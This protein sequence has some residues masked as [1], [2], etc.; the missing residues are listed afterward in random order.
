MNLKPFLDCANEL[1][2]LDEVE[3][4][5]KLLDNLPGYYRDH[6]PE[7]VIAL[8]NE[9]TARICTPT[10]YAS[11]DIDYASYGL[12]DRRMQE[13][14]RGILLVDEVRRLN[15]C[16]LRP[17][18]VDLGPGEYWAPVTLRQAKC[19]F[20]YDAITLKPQLTKA[21]VEKDQP[22]VFLALEIIEHLWNEQD[23]KIEAFKCGRL[24]DIIHISTPKYAFDVEC[25]DWRVRKELG[26]LRTYTP[27]EFQT[28]LARLFPEYY[29]L[30]YDSQIM[31][32]RLTL[33]STRFPDIA[34]HALKDVLSS[35]R[36]NANAPAPN[37]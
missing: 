7:E 36:I 35:E 37:V 1:V 8:R 23:I 9:I 26:H 16:G 12:D 15:K 2:R 21:V 31:Q 11:M 17:H 6:P 3:R 5:L 10:T 13:T 29:L 22:I 19:D 24:P 28:V 25:A 18:V 20:T 14:L 27:A 30:F 32:M 4:A 33:K 34:E